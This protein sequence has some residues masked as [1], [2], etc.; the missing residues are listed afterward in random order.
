MFNHGAGLL[1]EIN[2][3]RTKRLQ[4]PLETS[5]RPEDLWRSALV[6]VRVVMCG[7]GA[8]EDHA[9]IY[10]VDDDEAKKW[11]DVLERKKRHSG[12]TLDDESVGEV[13]VSLYFICLLR[14]V[15]LGMF[16]SSRA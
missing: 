16:C 14:N 10:N 6:M 12:V 9:I 8:P 4:D 7:R 3:L 2:K 15:S 5:I 11:D 13:E 1:A